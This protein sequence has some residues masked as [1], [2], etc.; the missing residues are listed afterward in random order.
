MK[1]IPGGVTAA[2]GFKASGA[3]VGV[4][5]RNNGKKDLALIASECECA[6]A[7]VYTLNRVKA[8]PL[9]V[10]MENI[11]NGFA[12]AIICNSGNANAC[13]PGGIENARRMCAAAAAALGIEPADVIVAST[14]VIGQTL[15]IKAIEEGLPKLASSL[16]ED[17]SDKAAEAIMTT[18]TLKKDI[19]VEFV[20]GGKTVRMGGIAKGSGMI[21]PNMGTMLAF[22]TTDAA[23][24]PGILHE[25]LAEVTKKTFNRVCVDGD[26]ST[27]DMCAVLANGLAENP[28][29]EWKDED[30]TVFKG[31]LHFICEAL[32]KMIASDGEGATKLITC[33][34]KNSRS[35][36]AAERLAV[37]VIS[38]SLVKTAMFGADANWG[39]VLCAMGYSKAPFR[40][41]YVDMSFK[42]AAGE[43]E[44]C[45]QGE[46]LEFDEEL[47]KKVLSQ[48]EVE[49]IVNL[50]EDDACAS[51]WGC[52]LTY[53][54]VK[55]NGDYRT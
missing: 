35:E 38:S 44:V 36:D 7:A 37:T 39:R 27:N 29:I 32:A 8:A 11:E 47:A 40:P 15:N 48:N 20:L 34:M 53:D 45:K 25:A 49:I 24:T 51:A 16:S 43:I 3:H 17:G 2:K 12:R 31:A 26:T 9:Y 42:S 4:K 55:I 54:Y 10:T 13:A 6:A 21:Q 22:I 19:A 14:G 30:Y 23:I 28:L 50:N 18:D 52:D 5:S 33:T 41:E 46:G 1:Q